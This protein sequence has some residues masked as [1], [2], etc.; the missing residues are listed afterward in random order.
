MELEKNHIFKNTEYVVWTNTKRNI[1]IARVGD[2]K[3]HVIDLQDSGYNTSYNLKKHEINRLYT[4]DWFLQQ[5][6]EHSNTWYI[7]KIYTE[8]H[9]LLKDYPE[10]I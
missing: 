3:A 7:L 5:L 6:K 4:S 2:N 8:H 10:I 1:F 9:C